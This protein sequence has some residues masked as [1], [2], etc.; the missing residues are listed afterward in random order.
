VIGIGIATV[1]LVTALGYVTRRREVLLGPDEGYLWYGTQRVLA[2]EQPVRDFRSYEPGRYWWCAAVARVRGDGIV[3]VRLASHLAACLALVV[4]VV[5]M[6]AADAPSGAVVALPAAAVGWRTRH[7]KLVDIAVLSLVAAAGIAVLQGLPGAGLALGV[8]L[9]LAVVTGLNLGAYAVG[10]GALTCVVGITLG[11]V[12]PRT[13]VAVALGGLLG[14]LPLLWWFA[15]HRGTWRAVWHARVAVPR[16]RGTTNLPLPIPW[17]WRPGTPVRG[18]PTPLVG[19]IVRVGF[20]AV[21]AIASGALAT[22]LAGWVP[23]VL[24]VP[25]AAVALVAFHHALSRADLA[26]L[27]L[28][29]PFALGCLLVLPGPVG[30]VAVVLTAAATVPVVVATHPRLRR[31]R[32]P[33]S[34]ARRRLRHDVVWLPRRLALQLDAIRNELHDE[35]QLAAVPYGLPLLA[36]LGRRSAVYDTYCIYPAGADADEELRR[37]LDAA[38]PALVLI[39][40]SPAAGTAQ[41]GFPATHPH[42]WAWVRTDGSQIREQPLPP[43]VSLWRVD[44]R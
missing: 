9:G 21:P 37:Q 43:R 10:A 18:A 36:A 13:L 22:A 42:A 16:T 15:A 27:E 44:D 32:A 28:A 38:R 23:P 11:L 19:W 4:L 5:V 33:Q 40:T 30:V 35:D 41:L 12:D 26:H 7:F 3:P 25:M 39:D 17:P 24:V 14:L 29:A 2:G 20:V 6:A 34:F 1:V 8:A 31:H